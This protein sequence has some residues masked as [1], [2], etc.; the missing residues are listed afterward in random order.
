[1]TRSAIRSSAAG[2]SVADL[3]LLDALA[4]DRQPRRVVGGAD[5]GH[6]S[7]LEALA[8]PLLELAEVARQAVRREHDLRAGLVQRVERV[9]ELLLGAGLGLEE[10]DVVD[11][12]HVDAA[13]R[14][15]EALDVMAVERAEEVVRERLGGRVAHGRAAAVRGD[16]VGDRVEQVGLAEAGRPADV[17][18]VVGEAGHLGDGER[19]GVG[20]AVGVADDELL[21]RVARVEASDRGPARPGR[22]ARAGSR[23]GRDELDAGVGPEDGGRCRRAGAVR[24]AARPRAGSRPAPRRRGCRRGARERTAVQ[25]TGARSTRRRPAATRR[26]WGASR[27]GCSSSITGACGVLLGGGRSG[28]AMERRGPWGGPAGRT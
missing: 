23:A 10:L 25:A 3:V 15:L 22:L 21:E 28:K 20:E 8:Q 5:V 17:Q 13:V 7:G 6:E 18:R 26:G 2:S 12:Q 24:S 14:G 1:M 19:G 4:Q 11:E 9:E 27:M 16:V